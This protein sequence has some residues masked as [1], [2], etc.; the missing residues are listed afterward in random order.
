MLGK[1]GCSVGTVCPNCNNSGVESK[2]TQ[3]ECET[4]F[5]V[6]YMSRKWCSKSEPRLLCHGNG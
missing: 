6:V 1:K 5:I 4:M 2:D 3:D